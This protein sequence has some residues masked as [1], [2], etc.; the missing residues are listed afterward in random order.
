MKLLE[1]IR[2]V[3]TDLPVV[4]WKTVP[5]GGKSEL[6]TRISRYQYAYDDLGVDAFADDEVKAISIVRREDNTISLDV[7]VV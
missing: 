1:F 4:I 3:K 6:T 7:E 2:T 5:T